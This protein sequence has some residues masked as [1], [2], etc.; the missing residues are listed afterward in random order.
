M[1]P[2]RF[3]P[4]PT[5]GDRR[6]GVSQLRSGSEICPAALARF[7]RVGGANSDKAQ[8]VLGVPPVLEADSRPRRQ[9]V[10]E[11]RELQFGRL[12]ERF[13]RSSEPDASTGG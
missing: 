8:G 11:A 6:G 5:K 7:D 3:T 1:S 2:L 10:D 13:G 4:R 12:L 9:V